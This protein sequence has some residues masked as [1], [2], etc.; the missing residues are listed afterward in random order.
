MAS[1]YLKIWFCEY[2]NLGFSAKHMPLTDD[3]WFRLNRGDHLTFCF[4]EVSQNGVRILRQ[5]MQMVFGEF[6]SSEN[7]AQNIGKLWI[8][9]VT[10]LFSSQTILIDPFGALRF[11]HDENPQPEIPVRSHLRSCSGCTSI[12][13]FSKVFLGFQMLS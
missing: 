4:F 9:Q 1:V 6:S 13:G 3:M 10:H 2:D 8:D 5:S 12:P 11:R 7:K